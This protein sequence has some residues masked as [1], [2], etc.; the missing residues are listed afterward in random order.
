VV[1]HGKNDETIYRKDADIKEINRMLKDPDKYCKIWRDFSCEEKPAYW[2]VWPFSKSKGW[3]E[4][5]IGNL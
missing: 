2:V 4:K 1:F 5:I 3:C